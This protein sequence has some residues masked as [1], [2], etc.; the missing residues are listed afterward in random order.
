MNRGEIV[1]MYQVT[2]PKLVGAI[3]L[4]VEI[5][6]TEDEIKKFI[7]N[8]LEQSKTPY[9]LTY[10]NINILIEEIIKDQ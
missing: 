8:I 4:L 3:K 9:S 2:H 10:N 1:A 7:D 6:Q 5:G